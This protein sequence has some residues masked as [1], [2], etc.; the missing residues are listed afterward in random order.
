M[1]CMHL[2]Y[3]GIKEKKN[4]NEIVLKIESTKFKKFSLLVYQKLLI[5]ISDFN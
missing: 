5:I 4:S 3:I 2:I 1:H